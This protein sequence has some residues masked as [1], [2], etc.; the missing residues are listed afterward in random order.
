[1]TKAEFQKAWKDASRKFFKCARCNEPKHIFRM[2]LLV[3]DEYVC[4]RCARKAHND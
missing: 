2:V 3:T 4:S 1:M